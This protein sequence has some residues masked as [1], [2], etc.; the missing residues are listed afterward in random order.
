L[1]HKK[2]STT[3]AKNYR[4]ISLVNADVKILT[5]VLAARLQPCAHLLVN[6]DQTGL[7]KGRSITNNIQRLEDLLELV[8]RHQ[9]SAV[10]ALLDYE[11]AFDRVDHDFLLAVLGKMG[12]PTRF[13]DTVRCLYKGRRSKILVNGSLTS[14]FDINR[15]VLQGD[16]LSP[17]LFVLA[18]E[19]LCTALRNHTHLGIRVGNTT[20]VT[21]CFADDS[22]IFAAN[23]AAHRAQPALVNHFYVFSSFKLNV[24]KTQL[25]T[26]APLP[27]PLEARAVQP[28]AP[29]KSLG[30]LVAPNLPASSRID[31]ALGRFRDR[32]L[33]WLHKTTS[34]A[35][36]GQAPLSGSRLGP[37]AYVGDRAM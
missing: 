32:L 22:Q 36:A 2:G 16:P 30:I 33:L 12:F 15:G 28:T 3:E 27:P 1:L 13:V 37:G 11:K 9:P 26:H 23:A 29:V 5:R 31:H 24:E 6:S 4:P 34:L 35:P 17:L 14:P 18:L 20:H 8:R 7:I 10:V 25:L 19:P 21:S